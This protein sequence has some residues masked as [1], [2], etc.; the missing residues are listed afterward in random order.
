M[1]YEQLLKD[2]VRTLKKLGVPIE[3]NEESITSLTDKAIADS[4]LSNENFTKELLEGAVSEAKKEVESTII[5]K[6]EKQA[7]ELGIDVAGAKGDVKT[8]M[9]MVDKHIKTE[10][11]KSEDEKTSKLTELQKELQQAKVDIQDK[12]KLLEEKET[13]FTSTLESTKTKLQ[14]QF[15][16]H[17][18]FASLSLNDAAKKN[19][20]VL[21]ERLILPDLE[22]YQ[23]NEKG[24]LLKEG[25]VIFKNEILGGD[26]TTEVA[27]RKDLI[28]AKARE[29]NYIKETDT[30]GITPEGSAR[31]VEQSG[32]RKIDN[33]NG[34]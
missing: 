28:E 10:L 12:I 4:I 13:E 33:Y 19:S 11:G 31:K 6:L 25:K 21:F 26:S 17:A 5:N 18:I 1:N 22:S 32:I 16:D 29:Y 9:S 30:K 23:S 34:L 8:I 7:K 2:T 27:T 3:F 20:K 14:R 24:Q 15:D